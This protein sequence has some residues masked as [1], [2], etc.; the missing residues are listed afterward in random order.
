MKKIQGLG[1]ALVGAAMALAAPVTVVV[2][3]QD[4]PP[5]SQAQ[6]LFE[7]GQYDQA[8]KAIADQR[9]KGT[10]GLPEAFLAAQILPKQDQKDRAKEEFNKLA[11]ANDA[12]WK[13]VGESS[14][15]AVD[16][17]RDKSMELATKA[18]DQAKSA[19]GD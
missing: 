2:R 17:D 15:A 13:L 4:L 1:A 11:S 14:R 16:D 18:V 5:V 12:V 7:A 19:E 9:T 8:L 6:Q 10:A 3:S